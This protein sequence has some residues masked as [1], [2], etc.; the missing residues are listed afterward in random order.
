VNSQASTPTRPLRLALYGEINM[1]LIDGSSIWIQSVCQ[2]LT[3][4]PWV[5]VTLLLR[6]PEERD[7]LTAPLRA[8][9]RIEL[10][11][12]KDRG[13]QP[14]LGP[15]GAVEALE[16]LDRKQ[17]FDIV[18]L[19]GPSV[20]EEAARRRA[21]LGRLW[22]YY[23]P[24]HQLRPGGESEHVRL[25]APACERLLCQTE[26]IL[27]LAKSAAPDQAS[28][29]VRLSPMIPSLLN[30]RSEGASG[31]PLKLV[32]AGK[33]A[34]EYYFLEMVDTFRRLRRFDPEAELHLIG[35]KIHNPP[36]DP[37]FKP[38]AEAALAETE[39]L[40]W[41]GGVGRDGALALLA[42]SDVALS[43][44]HPMM[45]RELATKVLEYGAANCS[46]L[47]NRTPLYEE[48][49]GADYPLFVVEPG[50]ALVVLRRLRDDPVL[51]RDAAARCREAARLYTFERVASR[52]EP[53]LREA[54]SRGGRGDGPAGQA[55]CTISHS[56]S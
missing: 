39:N 47:L 56:R 1:N 29:L 53:Y 19:R 10:V 13:D 21:F 31:G 7:L 23:L 35:D 9:P 24:P 40:I 15:G 49:L 5:E 36:E 2:M 30:G 44:R 41:H 27:E 22:I 32:Y 34:P 52:M 18:L 6:A 48:L 28:K 54:R 45:D 38:A 16:R 50:E 12:P 33:M 8:H 46:V 17:R 43:V 11:H 14:M 55:A 25:L 20:S 51:R 3:T 37:R 26:P 42:E 4:L